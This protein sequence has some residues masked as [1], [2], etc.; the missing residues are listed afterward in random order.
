M[1]EIVKGVYGMREGNHLRPVRAGDAPITLDK[2]AEERLVKLGV[3]KYVEAPPESQPD[4]PKEK[5]GRKGKGKTTEVEV[6]A[7]ADA[8]SAGAPDLPDL[9]AD[10]VVVDG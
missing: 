7:D 9:S 2:Q 10:D 1:V 6:S 3:A 8:D 4:A 5:T